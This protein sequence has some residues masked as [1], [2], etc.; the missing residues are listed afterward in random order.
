MDKVFSPFTD[1]LN[2]FPAMN[3]IYIY[4]ILIPVL[5]AI[6]FIGRLVLRSAVN[7]KVHGISTIGMTFGDID[8]MRKEGLIS[9]QEY[10][11]I[12]QKMARRELENQTGEKKKLNAAQI[13]AAIEAEP[14]LAKTLIG[15]G[16]ERARAA[17]ANRT[18][19]GA[20]PAPAVA[21]AQKSHQPVEESTEA[22]EPGLDLDDEYVTDPLY[23]A[24]RQR[25]EAKIQ[26]APPAQPVPRTQPIRAPQPKPKAGA[27]GKQ[28]DIDSLLA[29]G[30]ISKDE[31]D[32]LSALIEQSK[33]AK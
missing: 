9:E 11:E 14:E 29:Q 27:G 8:K 13:L 12:R 3:E 25:S 20:A 7:K 31:Y 22:L 17:L 19:P 28:L 6:I 10:K 2:R 33:G 21:P 18:E 1:L 16:S 26:Q 32:R 15:P 5:V 4:A 24:E 23:Q 30:L